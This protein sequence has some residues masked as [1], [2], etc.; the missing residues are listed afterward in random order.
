MSLRI[1]HADACDIMSA[2]SSFL[3]FG[4]SVICSTDAPLPGGNQGGNFTE[5]IHSRQ[6]FIHFAC[7]KNVATLPGY[8]FRE[9]EPLRISVPKRP[10]RRVT[11]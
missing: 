7:T 11:E 6:N 5:E 4:N 10:A 3:A 1:S 8:A 9:Y 2:W